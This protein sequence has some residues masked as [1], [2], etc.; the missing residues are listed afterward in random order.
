MQKVE[1]LAMDQE[2]KHVIALTTDLETSLNP[3]EFSQL[4]K[5][6]L[7][8]RFEKISLVLCFRPLV[9]QAIQNP[10]LQ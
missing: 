7:L 10:A 3:I 6:G 2:V 5:F 9:V 8:E 1:V 4:E